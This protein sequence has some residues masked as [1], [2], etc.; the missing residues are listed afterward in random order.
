MARKRAAANLYHRPLQTRQPAGWIDAWGTGEDLPPTAGPVY[1]SAFTRSRG[2]ADSIAFQVSRS[3]G[4]RYAC[5]RFS[6]RALP[7]SLAANWCFGL[8]L[9]VLNHP[10]SGEAAEPH[11]LQP[12]TIQNRWP[13]ASA[14]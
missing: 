5:A 7:D 6:F 14:P 13:A 12:V 8:G 11:Y 10:P 1:D 4:G 9:Q 2:S 3:P